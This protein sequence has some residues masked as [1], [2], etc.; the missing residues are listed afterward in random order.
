[1]T[2]QLK[3]TAKGQVT[4]PHAIL[5]HPGLRPGDRVGVAPL[6]DG[7]VELSAPGPARRI[8]SLFGMLHRPGHPPVSLEAMQDAIETVALLPAG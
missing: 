7:R 2:E 8:E 6:P 5:D 3:I 1:M 4:L